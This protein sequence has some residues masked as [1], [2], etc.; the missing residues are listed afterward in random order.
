MWL[1]AAV[2][3]NIATK[4]NIDRVVADF[5]MDN[6]VAGLSGNNGMALQ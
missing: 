3:A 2:G 1:S 6:A 5:P 4:L